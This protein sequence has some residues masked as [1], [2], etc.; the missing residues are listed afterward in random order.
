MFKRTAF[1]KTRFEGR[2]GEDY[3]FMDKIN[4]RDYR[5]K[6]VNNEYYVYCY[7]QTSTTHQGFIENSWRFLDVLLQRID[8]YE[9]ER[10]IV[11]HAK[12]K[13][14]DMFLEY[15]DKSKKRGIEIEQRYVGE[16]Q[17]FVHYLV[18]TIIFHIKLELD[19]NHSWST[20]ICIAY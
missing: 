4:S 6:P 8:M 19:I 20:L 15:Y 14:C 7:N 5:I 17:Q 11:L 9:N 12:K 10:D 3:L 13:Y 1:E 18:K 16:Y 2:Y